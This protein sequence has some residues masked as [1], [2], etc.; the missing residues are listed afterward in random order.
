MKKRKPK[1]ISQEDWDDVDSP[2]W[3]AEDF[4]RARPAREV[5]PKIMGKK[6]AEELLRP[7]GR[8]PLHTT[9]VST[10]IRL[11][12]D[13]VKKFKASGKGWQSRIN[14]ALKDWLKTHKLSKSA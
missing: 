6:A 9:K 13:V 8:P 7:R 3:T 10:S 2:E 1:H 12:A 5:L 14:L 4:A 11:D